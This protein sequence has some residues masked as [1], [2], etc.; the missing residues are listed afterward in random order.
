MSLTAPESQEGATPGFK[1]CVDGREIPPEDLPMRRVARTGS[2]LR[3]FEHEVVL[4]DGTVK[5]IYGSAAP[6]FDKQG[7]VRAVI[8]AQADIT[9]RK[10]T[11][12]A[13]RRREREFARLVEN[14]PD[15]VFRLDRALRHTYIS[16]VVERFTGLTPEQFQG[17]TGREVGLPPEACDMFEAHCR[18]VL[19]SG[20][21]SQLE[22][23]HG[24]RHFRTRLIPERALD[25]SV[26]A[27]LGITE[28][29]TERKQVERLKNEFVSMVS[30]ELRTPLTSIAGALGL[31]NGGAVG[32]LPA[33]GQ[34]DGGDRLPQQRTA[35]PAHQ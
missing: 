12:A 15:V 27:L 14:L 16:P 1:Y 8:A 2:P 26:E 32:P 29:I 22:F 25:G 6:L 19:T 17:K 34:G 24:G 4:D 21:E 31:I 35:H 30:H 18:E 9:A 28:D 13:L 23:G 5:A 3:N 33:P 20:E 7:R 10:Q 11:E